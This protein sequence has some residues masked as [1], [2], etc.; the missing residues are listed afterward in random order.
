MVESALAIEV[1]QYFSP[2]LIQVGFHAGL[3]PEIAIAIPM[4]SITHGDGHVPVLG[5]K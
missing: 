3:G 4:D 2:Y 1:S 5:L